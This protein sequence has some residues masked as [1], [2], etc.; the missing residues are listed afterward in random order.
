M[1]DMQN[2]R[3]KCASRTTCSEKSIHPLH[4]FLTQ[5]CTTAIDTLLD[6]SCGRQALTILA[7]GIQFASELGIIQ[8]GFTVLNSPIHTHGYSI[9]IQLAS[10]KRRGIRRPSPR[11]RPTKRPLRRFGRL[12]SRKQ[13]LA[14]KWVFQ[15][16]QDLVR[17]EGLHKR[18]RPIRA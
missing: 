3:V 7:E 13:P 4:T 17:F 5:P 10:K 14:V 11:R 9:F 18:Y 1:L 12:S 8:A 15:N 2:H 16:I 6:S